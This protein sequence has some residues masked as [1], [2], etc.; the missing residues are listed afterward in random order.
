MANEYVNALK[1]IQFES[2]NLPPNVTF[3]RVME[4]CEIADHC[5][6]LNSD[7]LLRYH[8]ALHGHAKS[9]GFKFKG[10]HDCDWSF[11]IRTV[12]VHVETHDPKLSDADKVSGLCTAVFT[13]LAF[14]E[15]DRQHL[16]R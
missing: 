3:T 9:L 12:L 15:D 13:A 11:L 2:L 5:R 6:N 8:D 7:R 14:E 1:R 10:W 16:M 4:L